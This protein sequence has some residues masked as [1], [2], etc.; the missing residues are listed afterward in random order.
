MYIRIKYNLNTNKLFIFNIDIRNIIIYK[1]NL[2]N[3]S[4]ILKNLKKISKS[5]IESI[6]EIKFELY[7]YLIFNMIYNISNNFIIF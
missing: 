4:N 6:L 7:S 1:Q 2:K 3:L 5:R